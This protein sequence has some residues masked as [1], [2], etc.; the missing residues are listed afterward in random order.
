MLDSML[1]GLTFT[2]CLMCL[3]VSLI[4]YTFILVEYPLVIAPLTVFII[5]TTVV[6][7]IKIKTRR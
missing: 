6:H 4:G 1:T 5:T 2:F 3:I 7:S